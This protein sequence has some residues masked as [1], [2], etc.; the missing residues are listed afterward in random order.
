VSPGIPEPPLST[1]ERW[2]SG[3]RSEHISGVRDVDAELVRV[4]A[5]DLLVRVV[6]LRPERAVAVELLGDAREGVAGPCDLGLRHRG[7][8]ALFDRGVA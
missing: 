1:G 4:G 5:D 7:L 6:D 3:I 2:Y 8:S